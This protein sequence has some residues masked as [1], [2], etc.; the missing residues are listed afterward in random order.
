MP[1]T[2]R[3]ARMGLVQNGVLGHHGVPALSRVVQ[4]SIEDKEIAST[5]TTA[6]V[7]TQRPSLVRR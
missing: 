6:W 3:F 7:P 2:P 5:G 4:E 1:G